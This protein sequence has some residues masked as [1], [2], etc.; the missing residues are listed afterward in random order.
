MF[1]RNILNGSEKLMKSILNGGDLL[2]GVNTW[3]VFLLG[4]SVAFV[5]WRESELQAID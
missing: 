1:R 4:Y 3:A 2:H 5:S